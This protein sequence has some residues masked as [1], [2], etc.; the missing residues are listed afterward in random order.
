MA[1]LTRIGLALAALLF[2]AA[3]VPARADDGVQ[4]VEQK[5]KAGLVYNFLKYTDWPPSRMADASSPMTVCIFGD[6]PFDGYL[7]PMAGRTVNQRSIVL[8]TIHAPN[9][10]ASCHL[11][12]VTAGEKNRISRRHIGFI[13]ILERTDFCFPDVGFGNGRRIR[14]VAQGQGEG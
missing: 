2:A 6:D 14:C 5:I 9:E 10:M 7:Q 3:A 13:F 11:L 1:L 8:R 4:L 12:F